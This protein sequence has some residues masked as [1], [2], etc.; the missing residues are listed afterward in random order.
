MNFRNQQ[1]CNYYS[2]FILNYSLT[3]TPAIRWVLPLSAAQQG[4]RIGRQKASRV[5]KPRRTNTNAILS[6]CLERSEKIGG[7]GAIATE[8]VGNSIKNFEL[9]IMNFRNQ[10]RRNYYSLFIV[11]SSLKAEPPHCD[12]SA[13][14]IYLATC[15]LRLIVIAA[16][17]HHSSLLIP[18]S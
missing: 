14:I 1:R 3:P 7:R 4:E 9:R 8:G 17:P 15:Y 13:F 12:G 2:L 11:N 5:T 10:Q 16:S 18:H 6:L